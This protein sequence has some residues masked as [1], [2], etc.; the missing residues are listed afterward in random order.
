MCYTV[1]MIVIEKKRNYYLEK[2][3]KAEE[4]KE[5]SLESYK[6]SAYNQ[7]SLSH[8]KF[9]D[10]YVQTGEEGKYNA[11]L[12][13]MRTYGYD[14]SDMTDNNPKYKEA[15]VKASLLLKTNGNVGIAVEEQIQSIVGK[16]TKSVAERELERER[17][18][19][20]R[21]SDR[22][23]TL[24]I[25]CKL[26]NLISDSPINNNLILND[27]SELLATINSR[28]NEKKIIN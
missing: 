21:S 10:N 24:E 22:I 25:R 28:L 26:N 5:Q 11:T 15:R 18:K 13:Y 23:R 20:I 4:M 16:F 2:K 7:L 9:V 8:R 27:N 6:D 19:A 17:E 12:A 14:M 3:R 1:I